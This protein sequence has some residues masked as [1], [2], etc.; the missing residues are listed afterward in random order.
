MTYFQIIFSISK[1]T[2]KVKSFYKM[3][4]DHPE[5]FMAKYNY[6]LQSMQG[7]G[8]K[9]NIKEFNL[10]DK[11]SLSS[12]NILNATLDNDYDLIFIDGILYI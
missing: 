5:W 3:L 8:C 11:I 4:L 10:E 12:D 1:N 2:S 9:K 6:A 7:R